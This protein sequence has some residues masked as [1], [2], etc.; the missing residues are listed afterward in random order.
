[1]KLRLDCIANAVAHVTL[2][3]AA[4]VFVTK[5]L[6]RSKKTEL[7]PMLLLLMLLRL[8]LHPRDL[9]AS[10]SMASGTTNKYTWTT[11]TTMAS[12]TTKTIATT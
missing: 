3:V 6:V 7:W 4:D 1:M 5:A 2:H 8:M 11:T 9:I 12:S 10:W